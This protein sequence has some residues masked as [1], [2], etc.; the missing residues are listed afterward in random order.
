MVTTGSLFWQ[1][2]QTKL[3]LRFQKKIIFEASGQ[4]SS[5]I[6]NFSQPSHF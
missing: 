2:K 3:K 5:D 6:F 4:A 1:S